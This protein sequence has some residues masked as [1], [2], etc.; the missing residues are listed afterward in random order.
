VLVWRTPMSPLACG[1]FMGTSGIA[2]GTRLYRLLSVLPQNCQ[3][4]VAPVTYANRTQPSHPS[5]FNPEAVR[6]QELVHRP[7]LI[8][9]LEYQ[10]ENEVRVTTACWPNEPGRLIEGIGRVNQVRWS[11][12]VGGISR[13]VLP[14]GA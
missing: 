1:R 6:N 14:K 7:H 10:H 9:G 2:L 11:C 13:S 8:K 4:Q 3:F 5:Y 12:A